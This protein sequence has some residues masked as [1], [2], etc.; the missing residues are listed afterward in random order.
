MKAARSISGEVQIPLSFFDKG[1]GSVP[2]APNYY[3]IDHAV[4][5]VQCQQQYEQNRGSGFRRLHPRPEPLVLSK[6]LFA[7]VPRDVMD[8]VTQ[9]TRRSTQTL[10]EGPSRIVPENLERR[11]EHHWQPGNL[12]L[13]IR[14]CQGAG[15]A[16][17]P[18]ILQYSFTYQNV[19]S[20]TGSMFIDV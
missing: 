1:R 12:K 13:P 16:L 10:G 9:S 20:S 4:V 11:A 6:L 19:Q 8:H 15:F 14:V 18:L 3:G 5:V 2:N 17:V 7:G